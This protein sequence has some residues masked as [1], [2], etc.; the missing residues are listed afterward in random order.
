MGTLPQASMR[1]FRRHRAG[2]QGDEAPPPAPPT[3]SSVPETH[4]RTVRTRVKVRRRIAVASALSLWGR[5]PR[6]QASL[7]CPLD[8][9]L[10]RSVKL[11]ETALQCETVAENSPCWVPVWG[12]ND[13]RN[14]QAYSRSDVL[15]CSRPEKNGSTTSKTK[16]VTTTR[17][18]N[19]CARHDNP[20]P[21]RTKP[22]VASALGVRPKNTRTHLTRQALSGKWHPWTGSRTR[23]RTPQSHPKKRNG[24]RQNP[25]LV[26]VLNKP[27]VPV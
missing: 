10:L 8:S 18:P 4:G 20:T 14:R 26:P 6:L 19:S 17:S 25:V 16:T 1:E 3:L 13:C 22:L 27:R 23:L 24:M 15:G 9:A 2:E 5:S 11:I 12:P 7:R 21:G